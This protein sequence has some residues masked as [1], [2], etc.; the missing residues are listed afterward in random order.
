M[1]DYY[2]AQ[3]AYMRHDYK[4]AAEKAMRL[5]NRT[6]VE[7]DFRGE[8]LRIAGESLYETGKKSEALPYLEE[9]VSS[10][11]NPQ[12][13]ALYII[14]LTDYRNGDYKKAIERLTPVTADISAMGQSAYLLIGESYMQLGNYNAATLALEKAAQPGGDAGCDGGCILQS[15]RS[16]YAGRQDSFRLFGRNA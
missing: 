9:Y 1:A 10:V 15:G 3:M 8:A 6:D 13:S 5:V 2:L 4:E 16:P 11:A 12:P 14:G 7:P